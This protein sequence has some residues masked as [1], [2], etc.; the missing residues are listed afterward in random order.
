VLCPESPGS[1]L[2]DPQS[3]ELPGR[4]VGPADCPLTARANVE[5]FG[6]SEFALCIFV[7]GA[8]LLSAMRK[9]CCAS[10]ATWDR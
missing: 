8:P 7:I 5:P 9:T 4:R 2:T 3:P 10:L 6:R 1:S